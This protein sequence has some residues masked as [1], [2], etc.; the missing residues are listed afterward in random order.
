MLIDEREHEINPG[1]LFV[2]YGTANEVQQGFEEGFNILKNYV[3]KCDKQILKGKVLTTQEEKAINDIKNL[4][5]VNEIKTDGLIEYFAKSAL[6]SKAKSLIESSTNV[7]AKN[8]KLKEEQKKQ[9]NKN[10]TIVKNSKKN[11]L[12]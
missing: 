11:V 10:K 4:K 9:N 1:I 7:I 3:E 5:I 6:V 12:K 2:V 8:E